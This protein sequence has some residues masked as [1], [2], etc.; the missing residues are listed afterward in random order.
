[1][2]I[3]KCG[4]GTNCRPIHIAVVQGDTA[5][6]KRIL[7]LM[8]QVQLPIDTIN[9]LRQ[10]GVVCGIY[11]LLPLL[12]LLLSLI[13]MCVKCIVTSFSNLNLVVI[14]TIRLK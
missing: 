10:V 14:I 11:S 9:H 8:S 1:M 2:M 4:F 13:V 7:L 6:V 12:L 3:N 5:L